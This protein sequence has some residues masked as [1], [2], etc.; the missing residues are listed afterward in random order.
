MKTSIY[1]IILA[2][3]LLGI[4]SCDYLDIVPDERPTEKDAF[5]DQKA[6]QK[7]LYSCYSYLPN[8]RDGAASLD[9]M[10]GDEVITGFEHE[11]FAKFPKGNYTA[12][13]P[14]ISYWN[15]LFGGL[16]QCYI[17]KNN[18][19]NV[20]GL[21]EKLIKDYTAQADFLIAYYHFLLIKCYGPSILIK[22]E[23]D[24]NTPPEDFSTRSSLDECV[25]FVVDKFDEAA[26]NLPAKRFGEEY[27]LATSVAA[28]ALK[29]RILL[30]AASPL[31]NGNSRYDDL[32]NDDGT[33][34]FPTS[35][36]LQKWQ[37]VKDATLDAITTAESENHALYTNSSYGENGYPDDPVIRTLRYNIIEPA[38]SEILWADT[39]K[40]GTYGLQNKSRPFV[41]KASWN[42]VGPTLAM[43][44]RFYTENGLPI[45]EDPAYNYANR[46]N[47]ITVEQEDEKVAQPGKKT[48]VYNLNREPRF[49]AWVSFHGGYYELMS[50]TSNGAYKDDPDFQESIIEGE[51][52]SRLVTSMLKNGN[53]GRGNRTNNYNPS[54]FLNKKG[55]DPSHRTK[56]SSEGPIE[57]PW[58]VIRLAELYLTMA[59][60]CVEVNDLANAKKYL[61]KVRVRAGIPTVEEAWSTVADLSQDKLREIVRQERQIELYLENHNFWDMRRWMLAE[62]AFNKKHNGFNTE[63]EDVE[64]YVN[65]TEIPFNRVFKSANYLLPIPIKDINVNTNLVQNPGY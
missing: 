64:N 48:A 25:Q 53:C 20:P 18:V 61:N 34:L 36:D 31:F 28:K 26:T 50:A 43:L 4:S 51:N 58:P 56:L 40:E 32:K 15:T 33:P 38:N 21:S 35:F 10:T 27:G 39:R 52:Y 60:A 63:A 9:L 30:Y 23:P 11:T 42:G 8:P 59:E 6:V 16:R 13:T 29:T 7:F 54:G 57:Y 17:M 62:E 44:D 19:A 45:S 14:V 1:S 41:S 37:L 22:E 55:C 2:F 24:V 5:K 47:V 49:Y 3:I 12:T 46:F 65:V